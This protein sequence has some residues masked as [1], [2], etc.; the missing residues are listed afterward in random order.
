MKEL[1]GNIPKAWMEESDGNVVLFH[2]YISP[3]AIDLVG[4]VLSTRWIG[5]G[6]K[7]DIFERSFGELIENS[8][9]VSVGSGT[10]ALHLAYLLA[11]IGPGDEVITPVFTC[12]ATNL[13]LLYIGAKPVFADIDPLTMNISAQS[14]ENRITEKTKAIVTVDYGGLPCDY[15]AIQKIAKEN[16]LIVIDDAAHA[17]GAKY[18][19]TQI[20]NLAD[21]TTFSFQ[22]IKHITTGDGGMIALRSD[23]LI[24][25]A[26]RLRWFGIDRKAK[27]GGIW[28]NDIHEIGFKY[29]L[30]DIAAAIGIANLLEFDE[31]SAHRKK[32][33][34]IY[35]S[36]LSG[37]SGLYN[38]GQDNLKGNEHA[39]WLH[40]VLVDDRE[41]LQ[42]KLR[43]KSI[44]SAQVHYRNDMYSVFGGRKDHFPNMDSVEDKYLVLPLHH[45]VSVENCLRICHEIKTGW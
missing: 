23:E 34:S 15:D 35:Y 14:I 40:T 27:Q 29:Q 28:Q 31:V 17:V 37:I 4:Q 20:G 26:R 9:T 2:P 8:N 38:V 25:K 6:P 18:K 11:G 5:Q 13:P 45:K 44:E 1:N 16:N 43:S 12:T 22:A 19:G 10:D 36:E 42:E 41:I 24:D 39:A 32:L 33:L 3:K 30:T 7:V 21:I